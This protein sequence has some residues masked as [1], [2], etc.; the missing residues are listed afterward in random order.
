M[1]EVILANLFLEKYNFQVYA[2]REFLKA[3]TLDYP[4][5]PNQLVKRKVTINNLI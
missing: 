3:N 2:I 1:M 4:V 5:P